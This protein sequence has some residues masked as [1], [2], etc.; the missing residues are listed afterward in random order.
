MQIFA[1]TFTGKIITLDVKS[2][3]AM[4]NIQAKVQEKKDIQRVQ[5]RLVFVRNSSNMVLHSTTTI[6]KRR[7][8][9]TS[10]FDS[11][12]MSIFLL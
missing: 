9:F 11:V 7:A 4:E 8:H 3:D 5:L 6:S 1:E 2:L 12:V 10:C